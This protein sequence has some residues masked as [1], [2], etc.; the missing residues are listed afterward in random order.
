MWL[1]SSLFKHLR[2]GLHCLVKPQLTS[3][4]LST[5]VDSLITSRRKCQIYFGGSH[6]CF[7]GL[8]ALDGRTGRQLWRQYDI[9]EMFAV[10]C[11]LDLNGDGYQDCIGAGRGGVSVKGLD[12]KEEVE[13]VLLGL[14]N[15]TSSP[16]G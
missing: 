2:F 4:Y 10:N 8:L 1:R 11:D 14:R 13:E 16:R 15:V 7:G 9:H 6:L 5:G 12:L 3:F